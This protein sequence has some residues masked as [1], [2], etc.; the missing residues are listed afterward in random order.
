MSSDSGVTRSRHQEEQRWRRIGALGLLLMSGGP[1]FAHNTRI[2]SVAKAKTCAVC[3]DA[4]PEPTWS[5]ECASREKTVDFVRC[6]SQPKGKPE[7]TH[8]L[9]WAHVFPAEHCGRSFLA[10]REGH[11]ACVDNMGAPFTG[12]H[13]AGNVSHPFR[14]LDADRDNLLPEA[15]DTN[16][17]RSHSDPVLIADAQRS[18]GSCALDIDTRTFAP[19]DARRGEIARM[20]LSLEHASPGRGMLSRQKRQLFEA[21]STQDPVAE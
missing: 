1:G 11:P 12:R 15:A 14:Y 8:R 9:A 3:V 7:T 4:G 18:V 2:E 5:C 16:R 20:L 10:W 6:G 21:W 17:L 13:G 19:R